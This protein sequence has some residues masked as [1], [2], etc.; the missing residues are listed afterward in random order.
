MKKGCLERRRAKRDGYL[1]LLSKL[2]GGEHGDSAVI[3]SG[4]MYPP[5]WW[6]DRAKTCTVGRCIW[7]QRMGNRSTQAG[8]RSLMPPAGG[9]CCVCEDGRSCGS[10]DLRRGNFDRTHKMVI[11]GSRTRDHTSLCPISISS[12]W[13]RTVAGKVVFASIGYAPFRLLLIDFLLRAKGFSSSEAGVFYVV[14]DS[15]IGLGTSQ[16]QIV[17]KRYRFFVHTSESA[18]PSSSEKME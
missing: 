8:D 15:A 6:R 10:S 13:I 3:S 7:L 9:V 17:S 11:L 2:K 5:L 4:S 16:I 14:A 1:V 18:Q 12:S